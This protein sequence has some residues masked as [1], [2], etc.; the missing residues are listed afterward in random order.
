MSPGLSQ[1]RKE[2][3]RP[4][5][6]LGHASMTGRASPLPLL[7]INSRLDSFKDRQLSD[8]FKAQVQALSSPKDRDR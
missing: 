1:L 5:S 4:A 6:E 3:P 7:G 8:V 2:L